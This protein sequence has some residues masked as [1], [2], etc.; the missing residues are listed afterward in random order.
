[1]ATPSPD[2]DALQRAID[3]EVVIADAGVY[4]ERVKA[5]NVRFDDVRPRAIVSCATT[6]DVR[7]VVAFL[8]RFGLEHATRSGGHGFAGHS[9]SRGVVVD[10]APMGSISVATDAVTVGA[11]ARLGGVYG[12]LQSHGRTIPGGTCPWVG[13]AGL[14]LGGGLGILG[15]M[16][17]VTSDS[18]VRAEIVLADGR[19]L[20]CDAS[21]YDD[22]FWALRGAGTGNFGVVTE[23][24]FRTVPAP[25]ATNFH[26]TWPFARVAEIIDAWQRWAPSGPDE[27]AASLKVTAAGDLDRSPAVDVY[28]AFF[29]T[30]SD[31]AELID[32]LVARA[33]SDPTVVLQ[34]HLSYPETRNYWA[35]LGVAE[36]ERVEDPA[37]LPAPRALM[38]SKSEFFKRPLPSDAIAALVDNFLMGR[39]PGEDRE[40]DFMPWAGGYNRVGADATAFVH[41]DE[42]FLLKHAAVVA[43]H[44]TSHEQEAARRW[45]TRSWTLLHP[46]GSQRAFQNFADPDLEAWGAAY[47]GSNY[48]RLVRVKARYD[49]GNFFRFPQS[50][51]TR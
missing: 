8:A 50:L 27:L 47:Y 38:F 2:W 44:A 48:A 31:A 17:G 36:S 9:T 10:V 25:A 40:L 15:R 14:A 3:G 1:M 20:V 42:L 23:M 51:P 32:T 7:E 29:G 21:H 46:W 39:R 34:R 6:N 35:Q 16:H 11:G 12:A 37:S 43:P 41:R 13:I 26:L 22:L 5:F 45:V 4:V 30:D 28:G 24:V 49:P 18:L 33:G 19:A